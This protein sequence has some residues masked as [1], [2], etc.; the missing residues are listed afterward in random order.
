MP[1]LWEMHFHTG[2]RRLFDW[3]LG[4]FTSYRPVAQVLGNGETL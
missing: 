3:E 1:G 2:I 4:F